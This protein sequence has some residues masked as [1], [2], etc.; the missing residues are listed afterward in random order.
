VKPPLRWLHALCAALLALA[1][2]AALADA[3]VIVNAANPVQALR[4]RDVDD[5]F[6]GRQRAFPD[7]EFALLFDLPR[8]S[9]QRTTFYR[10]L[11]GM[12]MAQVNSYWARLMFAGYSVPPSPLPD[13]AAM[14]AMVK[15]N[16][17]AIGYLLREPADKGVRVVLVLKDPAR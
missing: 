11:T 13:E 12:P 7:G 5:L 15:R 9:A 10:L 3:Y 6:M 1:S 14:L 8:D 4:R 16:P 17:S 2:S